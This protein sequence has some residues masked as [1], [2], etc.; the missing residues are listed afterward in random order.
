[1]T[2]MYAIE[3]HDLSKIEKLNN[4]TELRTYWES[5]RKLTR[6]AKSEHTL[7]R[8]QCLAEIRYE[9]LKVEYMNRYASLYNYLQSEIG[10]STMELVDEWIV[11]CGALP[12]YD[13][14]SN[15]REVAT[16]LKRIYIALH[17]LN[18]M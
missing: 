15:S 7:S 1:M 6:T 3:N 8:W 18:I 11:G 13:M 16:Q 17:E 9:E 2:D 14:S 5:V 12:T 4:I 10:S